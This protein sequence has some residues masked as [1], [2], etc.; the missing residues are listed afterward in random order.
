MSGTA[1]RRI[2]LVALLAVLTACSGGGGDSGGGGGTPP[3]NTGDATLAFGYKVVGSD[4]SYY[5]FHNADTKA[6]SFTADSDLSSA[7]VVADGALAGTAAIPNP[8]GVRVSGAT[9][10]LDPLTSAILRKR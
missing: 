5:V 9:V 6:V 3:P 2:A 1:L 10:T 4:G 7:A 8:T